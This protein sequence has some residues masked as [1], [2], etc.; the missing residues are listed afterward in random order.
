MQSS[1]YRNFLGVKEK[2]V[3]VIGGGGK[4]ALIN[5]ITEDCRS[6]GLTVLL[7]SIFPFKIPV[8]AHTCISKDIK[9]LKNQLPKELE[10]H[11]LVYIGKTLENQIIT[12]L[13][14][15]DIKELAQD[16]LIDHIFVEADNT[17]GKSLSDYSK[18]PKNFPNFVE[19]FI[20]VIG[21][22]AFNQKKTTN[23]LV[24]DDPFWDRKEVLTPLNI[25]AWYENHPVIKRLLKNAKFV[26]FFINKVE[27]IFVENLVI[28][29]AKA[30]KVIGADRVIIG[31]VFNSTIHVIR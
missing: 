31:S 30:F 20:I 13:K 11:K 22:D 12:G 26:T 10:K 5:R 17:A 16:P 18:I 23:W 4:T 8:E 9:I 21:A 19:R 28:P 1:F 7:T 2:V 25:T 27:N 3:I 29:V 15:K 6:L 14:N 24:T